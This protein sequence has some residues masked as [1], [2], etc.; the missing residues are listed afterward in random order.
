MAFVGRKVGPQPRV[1]KSVLHLNSIHFPSLENWGVNRQ[2]CSVPKD[3]TLTPTDLCQHWG[4]LYK[5]VQT[6]RAF[7]ERNTPQS[8]FSSSFQVICSWMVARHPQTQPHRVLPRRHGNAWFCPAASALCQLRVPCPRA[9]ASTRKGLRRVQ[10]Q[11]ALLWFVV[12]CTEQSSHWN[13]AH[14][15]EGS[16]GK[17]NLL[18]RLRVEGSKQTNA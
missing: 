11:A 8:L 4:F 17:F 14:I 3:A 12:H 9:D 10:P 16:L 7:P 1:D 5:S 2:I 18:Q 15:Q 13:T 6:N